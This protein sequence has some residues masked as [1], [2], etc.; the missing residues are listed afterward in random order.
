MGEPTLLCG[1]SSLDLLSGVQIL[2]KWQFGDLMISEPL[3]DIFKLSLSN[4]Y[5]QDPKYFTDAVTIIAEINC[6]NI[7]TISSVFY[8]Q[9]KNLA[10]YISLTYIFRL[11]S[12]RK[13]DLQH[14]SLIKF[15]KIFSQQIKDAI[16]QNEPLKKLEPAILQSKSDLNIFFTSGVQL[17]TFVQIDYSSVSFYA[18][19][20]T[21]HLQTGM[22]SVIEVDPY[23]PYLDLAN[24]LLFFTFPFQRNYA[25]FEVH[26][27]YIPGLSIQIISRQQKPD[28]EF[29]NSFKRP[30]T[31]IRLREKKVFSIGNIHYEKITQTSSR[32]RKIIKQLQVPAPWPLATVVILLEM[33]ENQRV[34]GCQLQLESLTNISLNFLSV[35]SEKIPNNDAMT[36]AII[37]DICHEI[38]ISGKDDFQI[39]FSVA[40]MFDPSIISKYV[41]T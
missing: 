22:T 10:T 21:S 23:E 3:E 11:S 41:K 39:I 12:I 13:C 32:N 15:C 14:P 18:L 28:D 9:R 19:C 26:D 17:N 24:F 7:A 4:L 35:L 5:R 16:T 27:R 34:K 31:Y 29:F 2:E 20:L 8:L 25:S 6:L 36:Q 1:I 38:K 37:N 30:I 40:S 33:P